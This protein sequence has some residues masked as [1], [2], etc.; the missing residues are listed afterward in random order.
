MNEYIDGDYIIREYEN[1][2][3][4]RTIISQETAGEVIELPPNPLNVLKEENVQLKAQLTQT[5]SEVAQTNALL[6]EF[7]ESMV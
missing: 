7:I 5:N 3:I 1:G 2:T 6:L 4:V